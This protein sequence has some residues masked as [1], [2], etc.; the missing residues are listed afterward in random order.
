MKNDSATFFDSY[1]NQMLTRIFNALID[2]SYDENK[3]G[4]RQEHHDQDH[5]YA[6]PDHGPGHNADNV[7]S[8]DENIQLSAAHNTSMQF[9]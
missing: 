7:V 4:I 3:N 6:L 1:I 9:I 8:D 5:N 2:M